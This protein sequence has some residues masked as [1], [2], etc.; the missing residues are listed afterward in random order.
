MEP[1]RLSVALVYVPV[2]ETY[3]KS[4]T[5][6]AASFYIYKPQAVA[7]VYVE[8]D[9]LSKAAEIAKCVASSRVMTLGSSPVRQ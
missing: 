9:G 1:A 3:T 7:G 6:G 4:R 5:F 2:H 8:G